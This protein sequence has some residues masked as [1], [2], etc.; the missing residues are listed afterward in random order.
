[1]NARGAD[2]LRDGLDLAAGVGG[3]GTVR[4]G[5]VRPRNKTETGE[6]VKKPAEDS[7]KKPS[8]TRKAPSRGRYVDEYAAPAS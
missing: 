2:A 7:R 3:G 1:M 6:K 8:P 4:P 5:R